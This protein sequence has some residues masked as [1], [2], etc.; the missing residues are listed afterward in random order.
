MEWSGFVWRWLEK[1]LKQNWIST[2]PENWRNVERIE[3]WSLLKEFLIVIYKFVEFEE[4]IR[5]MDS[6]NRWAMTRKLLVFFKT[7]LKLMESWLIRGWIKFKIHF[8]VYRCTSKLSFIR[9]VQVHFK[10]LQVDGKK[11]SGS[12]QILEVINFMLQNLYEQQ[13]T[14]MEF[15]NSTSNSLD[16]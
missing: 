4:E 5:I 9:F 2:Q 3:M 13:E 8:E 1:C 6:S 14:F 12:F 16:D 11:I 7:Y 10:R 15:L